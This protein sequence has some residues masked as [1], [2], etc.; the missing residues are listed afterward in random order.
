MGVSF[1]NLCDPEKA[2]D[3]INMLAKRNTYMSLFNATQVKEE[4]F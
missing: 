4:I 3:Q 2:F 1:I